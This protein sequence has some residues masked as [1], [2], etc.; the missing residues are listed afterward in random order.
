MG[1]GN[2]QPAKLEKVT[3]AVRQQAEL[4]CADWAM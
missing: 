3:E 4:R 1:R 2:P